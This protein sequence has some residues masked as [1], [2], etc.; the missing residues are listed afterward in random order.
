MA[1]LWNRWMDAG[2]GE[3][4]E[5]YTM[6]TVNAD[7]HPLMSRMHKPDPSLAAD[8]Q[9]KRSVV[10]VEMDD[11]DTWLRGSIESAITLL[12]APAMDLIKADPHT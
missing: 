9:D 1:G 10:A 12:R 11:V 2:T 6:L 3:I 4:V 5:S 8:R 7:S